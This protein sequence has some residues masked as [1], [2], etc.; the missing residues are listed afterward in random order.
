MGSFNFIS[1]AEFGFLTGAKTIVFTLLT[2]TI[3]NAGL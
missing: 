3:L 2:G 1:Q